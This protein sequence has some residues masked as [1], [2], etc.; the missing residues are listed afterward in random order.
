MVIVRTD[1]NRN[2]RRWSAGTHPERG[3]RIGLTRF[4]CALDWAIKAEFTSVLAQV[5]EDGRVD[6]TTS[7]EHR[8]TAKTH[9]LIGFLTASK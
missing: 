3:V 5:G 6:R 9:F 2:T 7:G 1:R 4:R 8:T